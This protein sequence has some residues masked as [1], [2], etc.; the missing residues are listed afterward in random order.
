MNI[1]VKVLTRSALLLAL[2]IA[3]Q[4]AKLQWITGPGINAILILAVGYSGLVSGLIIG[5]FTP[6]LAFSQGIMPLAVAVPFIM[7][8][9]ALYCLGFF[10]ARKIN[11]VVG[12]AVGALLKFSLLVLAVN[13]VIQVPPKVSQALSFPQLVTAIIGGIIAIII[14]KG[15]SKINKNS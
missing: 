15:I 5:L 13:F 14:L 9:N 8:G 2:A 11:D 10:W 12:I 6:I 7:L 1:S 3:V 4:Q